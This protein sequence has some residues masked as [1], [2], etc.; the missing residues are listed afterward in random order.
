[1]KKLLAMGL[2]LLVSACAS[3]PQPLPQPKETYP[4]G[5]TEKEWNELSI[6]DKARIRRD[7]YFYEKGTISFVDPQMEVEGK[8]KLFPTIFAVRPR[9]PNQLSK[10][11]KNRSSE[12]F[13]YLFATSHI[14][15]PTVG[16]LIKC[17]SLFQVFVHGFRV[18]VARLV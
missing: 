9:R 14:F 2:M 6:K 8:K 1:M 15:F 7:F 11:K 5:M 3:E 17:D 4:Y 18:G 10:N 16:L 12:R 13:F